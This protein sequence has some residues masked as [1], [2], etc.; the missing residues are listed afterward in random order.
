MANHNTQPAPAF[1]PLHVFFSNISKHGCSP[2]SA[3]TFA[4]T[5][6]T[7][8]RGFT[9]PCVAHGPPPNCA[10]CSWGF[11][12]LPHQSTARHR[13]QKLPTLPSMVYQIL[14]VIE[15]F[16]FFPINGFGVQI[17][18]AIPCEC[19][20]SFSFSA[21][22]FRRSAFLAPYHCAA[23]SPLSLFL[24]PLSVKMVLYPQWLHSFSLPKFTSLCT[25]YL[26]S[27]LAP[28][29][30]IVALLLRQYP[31]YSKWFDVDLAVL[32]GQ[33]KLRV[34]ILLHHLN[35]SSPQNLLFN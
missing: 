18:C 11:T 32:Q 1:A 30:Q 26:P 35:S 34:P 5:K 7:P 10:A 19:F 15:T 16:S 29:M 9:S 17:F 20:H 24:C 27:S 23:L 25:M 28:V 21:A 14:V 33:E 31:R 12:L 6:C 8:S 2:G 22:T 3:G 13:A 4:S